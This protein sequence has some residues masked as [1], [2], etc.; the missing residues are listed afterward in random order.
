MAGAEWEAEEVIER[1]PGLDHQWPCWCGR[2][3]GSDCKPHGKPVENG[4]RNTCSNGYD[5]EQMDECRSVTKP[6]PTLQPHGLQLARLP[7][8]SLSPRVSPNSSPLSWWCHPTIST[9]VVPFSSYPQSFPASGSFPMSQVFASGGQSIGASASAS[10]LLMN[11]QGWF[12]WG[13]TGLISLLSKG[14]S[15]VFS[16][17]TVQKHQFFS[18]GMHEWMSKVLGNVFS[19]KLAGWQPGSLKAVPGR[20]YLS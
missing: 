17:A 13:W 20:A 16:S 3:S 8:P 14:L 7:C 19:L 15:R 2:D 9:S 1:W 10:A 11:I 5:T 4:S 18:A 6:C 12:P